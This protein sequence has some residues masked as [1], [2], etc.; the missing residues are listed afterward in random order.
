VPTAHGGV[1]GERSQD[2]D[3]MA[4]DIWGPTDGQEANGSTGTDGGSTDLQAQVP[5]T[6]VQP[7]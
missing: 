4:V 2:E 3:G 6:W 5:V 7:R 1:E